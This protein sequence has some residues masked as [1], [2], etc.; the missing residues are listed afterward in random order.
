MTTPAE[1]EKRLDAV[2][3]E[4]KYDLVSD[5]TLHDPDRFQNQVRNRLR[6]T[7]EKDGIDI[8]QGTHPHAF[9]DITLNGFGV[10]VKFTKKDSWL[11]VGNSVFEGMRTEGVERVYVIFGKAGGEP[12][13]KWAGYED[14]V[15][16][17][18]VSHAPRFVIE[19][20]TDRASLFEHMKISYDRFRTLTD[21]EKMHHIREYSRGRLKEGERLWWLEQTHAIPMEVRPYVNLTDNEKRVLRAEAALL[22]PQ[23]CGPSRGTGQRKYIDAA[24]YLLMHHGVFCNQARD[25]FSAGSV[26][27]RIEPLSPDEPYLSRALRDIAHLMVD[28]AWRLDDDLFVEYWGESCLPDHRIGE[29]VE[30]A[31][32][33]A[34]DWLPSENITFG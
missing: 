22:C 32:R 23:V 19:M 29:W 17:V 33:Y 6:S 21:D 8:V 16:H 3:H 1:F 9:P 12:D 18:R 28:A 14:C 24:L 34:I 27:H 13:V 15:T 7:F 10:E 26:A 30:K 31:D 25:L 11:S 4:L 2:V 5:S 20:E